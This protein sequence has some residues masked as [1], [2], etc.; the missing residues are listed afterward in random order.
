MIKDNVLHSL[1]FKITKPLSEYLKNGLAFEEISESILIFGKS[2][3]F[4]L[5]FHHILSKIFQQKKL[6]LIFM[7]FAVK[8]ILLG[9]LESL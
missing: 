1:N 6:H 3:S 8:K 4:T 7:F 5:S 9:L 2:E